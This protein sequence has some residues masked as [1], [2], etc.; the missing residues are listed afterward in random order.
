MKL[1]FGSPKPNNGHGEEYRAGKDK[2]GFDHSVH[3]PYVNPLSGVNNFPEA[4]PLDPENA[5]NMPGFEDRKIYND[6]VDDHKI[7]GEIGE[8]LEKYGLENWE[9]EKL[10]KNCEEF[11]GN[12]DKEMPLKDFEEVAELAAIYRLYLTS[13]NEYGLPLS[14]EELAKA[15]EEKRWQLAGLYEEQGDLVHKIAVLNEA[16]HDRSLVKKGPGVVYSTN[17]QET[18]LFNEIQKYRK[19]LG[20]LQEKIKNSEAVFRAKKI[21]KPLSLKDV[22]EYS[23]QDLELQ[24][25][26]LDYL[27]HK[28]NDLPTMVDG[29][30]L[31]EQQV[32][33]VAKEAAARE[34]WPSATFSVE[35]YQNHRQL[36]STEKLGRFGKIKYAFVSKDLPAGKYLF[37]AD[38]D[39]FFVSRNNKYSAIAPVE[40]M[41]DDAI[42]I[43]KGEAA[44][45]RPAR[46]FIKK[47]EMAES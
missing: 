3:D 11:I 14:E 37:K 2:E 41:L 34:G 47:A 7:D 22:P 13:R 25:D 16:A 46:R 1:F 38:P 24:Q 8:Y 42:I 12:R 6:V 31:S 29:T 28:K 21:E 18:K 5:Y 45:Q 27:T 26:C 43:K 20:E 32:R 35:I 17:D 9:L 30:V 39:R 19:E 36:Y 15:P 33:E 10:M 44:R 23:K 4:S 40:V